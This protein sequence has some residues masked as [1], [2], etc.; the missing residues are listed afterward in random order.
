MKNRFL[1]F[2]SYDYYPS[3]GMNDLKGK[4]ETIEE[5]KAIFEENDEYD[6]RHIYDVQE[7][8]VIY[9]GLLDKYV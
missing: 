7:D 9:A 8:I 4:A 5:A 3:G 6:R 2:C 1:I